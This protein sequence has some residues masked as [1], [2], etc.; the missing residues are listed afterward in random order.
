[1]KTWPHD[2]PKAA[3]IILTHARQ[4]KALNQMLAH[5]ELFFLNK[6]TY[7]IIIFH[8]EEYRSY[9]NKVR[10]CTN[11]SMFFQEVNFSLPTSVNQ[12]AIP[13]HYFGKY[14]GKLVYY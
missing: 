8:E 3:I 14:I 6:F 1:M 12:S 10:T 7:P 9:V 2:K 13:V 11:A 4:F 5:L